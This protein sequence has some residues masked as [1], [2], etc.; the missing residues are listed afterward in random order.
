M[1]L[2]SFQ[3]LSEKLKVIEM[4]FRRKKPEEKPAAPDYSFQIIGRMADGVLHVIRNGHPHDIQHISEE[5]EMPADRVDDIL[6][7]LA[8]LGLVEKHARITE[9]GRKFLKLP[10]E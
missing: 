3:C 2:P 5:L 10:E 9:T 7:F 1:F 6:D 4:L 8:M